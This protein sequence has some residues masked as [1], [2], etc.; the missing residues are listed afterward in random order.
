MQDRYS[1]AA[2]NFKF[3]NGLNSNTPVSINAKLPLSIEIKEKLTNI[4]YKIKMGNVE[5]ETKSYRSLEVGQKYWANVGNTKHGSLQISRLIKKPKIMESLINPTFSIKDRDIEV[6]LKE[7]DG[8]ATL[9][10]L[11]M[12]TLVST[13]SKEDFSFLTNTFL[14]FQDEVLSLP[15]EHSDGKISFV[16]LKKKR[17]FDNSKEA[18]E[19]YA[20]FNHLGAIS[21]NIIYENS[22]ASLYITVLYDSIKNI[23][24]E[25]IP[26][27]NKDINDITIEV[28]RD[29]NP[30]FEFKESLLDIRG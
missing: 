19:F 21:G 10:R 8:F 4:R 22:V 25:S 13:T 3:L 9:K 1:Q 14:S 17:M 12:D 18:I 20:I 26:S 15:I 16:Q 6:L 30:I 7:K 27:L 11:L 23:L 28:K 2:N 24:E 5:L 29:I